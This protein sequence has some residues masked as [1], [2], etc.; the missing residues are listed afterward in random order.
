MI[1]IGINTKDFSREMEAF[2]RRNERSFREA[3]DESTHKAEKMAKHKVNAYTRGSRTKSGNLANRIGVVI[4]NRGYT[5]EVRSMAAYSQAFEEGQR[6]HTIRIRNKRVLAGPL[7]GAPAGWNVSARSRAMGFATY[8]KK[9]QHPGTYPRPFMFPS[10][11]FGH[12]NLEKRIQE[13]LI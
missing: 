10:W 6:P 13:A 11:R 7:R 4:T 5:G 2:L 9:V 12:R 8:G 1:T 3:V